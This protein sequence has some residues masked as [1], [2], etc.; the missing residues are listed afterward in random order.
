MNEKTKWAVLCTGWLSSLGAWLASFSLPDWQ[1]VVT[2]CGGVLF[3]VYT[4]MQM[5]Y[6]WRDKRPTDRRA[7]RRRQR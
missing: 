7:S 6:L 1:L 5:Y 4:A 2:I 3:G